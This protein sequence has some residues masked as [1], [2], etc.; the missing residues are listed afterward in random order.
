MANAIFL[1]KGPSISTYA[2][3]EGLRKCVRSNFNAMPLLTMPT[4]ASVGVGLK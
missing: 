4:R 2:P 1:R 3:K